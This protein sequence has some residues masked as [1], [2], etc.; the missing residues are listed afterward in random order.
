MSQTSQTEFENTAIHQRLQAARSACDDCFQQ[1]P[2][3]SALESQM[4]QR[5]QARR[6]RRFAGSVLAVT[7]CVACSLWH[8]GSVPHET[9]VSEHQDHVDVIAEVNSSMPYRVQAVWTVAVPVEYEHPETKESIQSWTLR[10]ISVPLD[11]K[12]LSR[13]EQDMVHRV[14]YGQ[15]QPV[16]VQL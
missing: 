12:S 8:L 1:V 3:R 6:R 15:Q 14:M 13:Q 4:W 11:P 9:V 16:S 10:D 5:V 2:S 7:F